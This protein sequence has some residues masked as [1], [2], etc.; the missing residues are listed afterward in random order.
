MREVWD[1]GAK[2]FEF[3]WSRDVASGKA[4]IEDYLRNDGYSDKP[5]TS[6][7]KCRQAC[8][9]RADCLMFRYDPYQKY[10]GYS[11][12]ISFGQPKTT[13]QDTEI[14]N[15]LKQHGIIQPLRSQS[16][17]MHSEWRLDR[18]ENMRKSLLAILLL[19]LKSMMME[20]KAGTGELVSVHCTHC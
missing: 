8:L 13:Y 14:R 7:D 1:N 2:E 17:S 15:Q 3:S 10:C 5:Y 4:S 18:V 19:K 20:M 12:S 16:E 11:S 6:V 9:A